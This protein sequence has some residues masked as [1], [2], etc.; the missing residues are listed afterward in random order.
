MS[1]NSILSLFPQTAYGT[2]ST[3]TGTPQPAASYYNAG[4]NLQTVIWNLYQFT[5]EL[6]IQATLVENPTETD[7]I[8]VDIQNCETV[9]QVSYTNISG[10]FVWM[11]AKIT[12]FSNGLVN[13]VQLSY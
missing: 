5:G 7:W 1:Q 10:N 2:Q 13:Y 11:R 8:T 9:T 4:S 12:N 6:N 3:V